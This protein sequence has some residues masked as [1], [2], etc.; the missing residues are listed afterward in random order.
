M[1]KVGDMYTLGVGV[2]WLTE[3]V[4]LV[5]PWSD[6]SSSQDC[7][8]RRF[9]R[10]NQYCCTSWQ[11][12]P[13]PM[14]WLLLL[15]RVDLV[16]IMGNCS[17]LGVGAISSW[18]NLLCNVH[19]CLVICKHVS[20]RLVILVIQDN[21]RRE[22]LRRRKK[23]EAKW[24]QRQNEVR[25]WTG[26]YFFLLIFSLVCSFSDSL[27]HKQALYFRSFNM[28]TYH[29]KLSCWYIVFSVLFVPSDRF[30]DPWWFMGMCFLAIHVFINFPVFLL[31]Q[32]S[33]L[34]PL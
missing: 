33:T 21:C 15:R 3:L 11:G 6:L 1:K 7:F 31:S 26:L 20:I 34:T 27:S 17:H 30:F 13:F 2:A 5:M 25:S 16:P 4:I 24:N 28:G 22:W 12:H 18:C 32:I 29:Y 8:C 14:R 23:L 9:W 19:R 10:I